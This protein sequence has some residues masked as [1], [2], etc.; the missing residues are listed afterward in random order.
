[1]KAKRSILLLITSI[2]ATAYFIYLIAYFGSAI[3]STTGSAQAG[4]ALATALVLPHI[5]LIA[6]GAIFSWLGFFLRIKGLTLVGAILF[7]IAL[8]VFLPYFMFSAPLLILG[9]IS[10]ANQNKLNKIAAEPKQEQI[11]EQ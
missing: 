8:F 6:V 9:F 7:T 10:F 4:A 1:M 3:G 2:L 5:V 11:S